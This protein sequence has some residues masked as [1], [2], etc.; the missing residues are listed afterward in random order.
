MG[1]KSEEIVKFQKAHKLT[2]AEMWEVRPGSW[3]V[4]H[5]AIER[6]VAQQGIKF[7]RP[8]I[9]EANTAEKVMVIC[10]FGTLGD[11]TEWS[12]GEASPA[13][14]KIAYPA[15]IAEKRA[16][17]RVAIKLLNATGAAIY[18]DEEVDEWKGT[19]H[20]GTP[21]GFDN[22]EP[23]PAEHVITRD[24]GIQVLTVDAQ[25]P[26]FSE[27]ERELLD[28]KSV[29]DLKRWKISAKSRA[30]R[31]SEHWRTE[32]NNRYLTYLRSL[33]RSEAHDYIE[34]KTG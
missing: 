11:R 28:R 27:L 32:L 25:R 26:I 17:D 10:V 6:I 18:S 3:A 7:E 12:F 24:D 8:A 19:T 5:S 33:E 22:A 14:C 31:L 34:R 29:E 13:N 20:Q 23:I 9:I 15:S 4:K 30:S 1:N 21:D 2:D 16:K